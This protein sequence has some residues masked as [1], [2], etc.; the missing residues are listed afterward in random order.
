MGETLKPLPK[1]PCTIPRAGGRLS[2][3]SGGA[4]ASVEDNYRIRTKLLIDE[5]LAQVTSSP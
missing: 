1:G 3:E 4:E 2:R 5:L